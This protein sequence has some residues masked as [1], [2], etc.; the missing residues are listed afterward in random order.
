MS[1]LQV[2]NEVAEEVPTDERVLSTLQHLCRKLNKLSLI[3]EVLEKATTA[4]PRNV[5][6][7]RGLFGAYARSACIRACYQRA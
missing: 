2:C 7:L 4:D 3:R 6:L 1:V 5:G